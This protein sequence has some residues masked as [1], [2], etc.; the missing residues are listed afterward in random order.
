MKS[1]AIN[2]CAAT[3]ALGSMAYGQKD[4]RPVA[5]SG[6][7]AVRLYRVGDLTDLDLKNG[8]KSVGDIDGVIID[9]TTGRILFALVGKGGVMGIGETEYLIPWQSIKVTAKDPVKNEGVVARTTLTEEQIKTAPTFKKD[10]SVDAGTIRKAR[11]NASLG[12]DSAWERLEAAR[13]VTSSDLKGATVKSKDGKD[14]GKIDEIVIAPEEGMIAYTVLGSG[15]VL[16]L[17]E[18]HYAL[19][20]SVTDISYDKDHKI[21]VTAPLTKERLEKAPEYDSKDWKRMSTPVWIRDM[22]TYWQTDPYW[23]HTTPASA[24]KKNG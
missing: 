10:M 20:L 9:A 2:L 11:E 14:L 6:D 19:P 5:G 24:E 12:S 3:L 7:P 22:S 17:G 18:K 4:A 21:F 1:I 16:G 23:M 13:L 8:D 15:G